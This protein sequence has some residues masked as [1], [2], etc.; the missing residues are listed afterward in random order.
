M[1]ALCWHGKN[2]IRCDDVPD[3]KIEHPRDAIIKVTSCATGP[4]DD[5]KG[6]HRGYVASTSAYTR[7]SLHPGL[8]WGTAAI[9]LALVAMRS[10]PPANYSRL[11]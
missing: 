10:R 5:S 11:M 1:K 3:P 4:S 8:L 7:A 9:G 2:D 6:E